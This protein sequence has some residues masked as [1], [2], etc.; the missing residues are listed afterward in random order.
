MLFAEIDI[1]RF[2]IIMLNIGKNQPENYG[3][4]S[5]DEGRSCKVVGGIQSGRIPS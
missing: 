3:G 1:F 4:K 5:Y 2:M